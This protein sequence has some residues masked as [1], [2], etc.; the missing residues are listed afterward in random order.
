MLL[1]WVHKVQED[2]AMTTRVSQTKTY[3]KSAEK[4][5]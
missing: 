1:Y 4:H 2:C 5:K 3:I